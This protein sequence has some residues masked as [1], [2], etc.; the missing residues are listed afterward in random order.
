MRVRQGAIW[1]SCLVSVTLIMACVALALDWALIACYRQQLQVACDAAAL[2]G[3]AQLA[4]PFPVVAADGVL[5]SE[6]LARLT[7]ARR[8]AQYFAAQNLVAGQPLMLET[9]T[10]NRP[11][12]NI[13]VGQLDDSVTAGNRL[14][15][16]QGWGP[17]NGVRVQVFRTRAL[18][19]PV[20]LGLGRLLG[21]PGIDLHVLAE[22]AVDQRIFGF[23]PVEPVRVPLVPAVISREVLEGGGALPGELS[24][25]AAP[26][27][28]DRY[29]LD[30]SGCW[31]LEPDGIPELVLRFDPLTASE[32]S[33]D[34]CLFWTAPHSNLKI[35]ELREQIAIGFD[36]HQLA[37]L[38]G[39]FGL[40]RQGELRLP[41]IAL[42]A[43]AMC[44]PLRAWLQAICGQP[45]IWTW[46]D[47]EAADAS[48]RIT[49]FLAARLVDC[50]LS[51]DGLHVAIQ[52][53]FLQ[54]CTAMVRSGEL[55]NPWLGK[56]ALIR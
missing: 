9:N 54:T 33:G 20:T 42:P 35:G 19:D 7:A 43:S 29:A 26:Q 36:D 49:G 37:Q 25:D 27:P 23:R 17:C 39:E 46:G 56:L 48:C 41:G 2:A 18:G 13:V 21:I 16:W 5:D 3:A 40:P 8:E 55:R 1:L 44:D 51:D 15:P 30:A 50:Y 6:E 34:V 12:G 31:R 28:T 11:D 22:A 45:R 24:P 53:C 52:P 47:W 10:S 4:V 38:G 14:T 32:K